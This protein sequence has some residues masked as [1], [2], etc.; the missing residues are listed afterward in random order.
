M[1]G[2]LIL[3]ALS[4]YGCFHK[5]FN[6]T[7]ERLL[8]F[9]QRTKTNNVVVR[10]NEATVQAAVKLLTQNRSAMIYR[11]ECEVC[12]MVH[13]GPKP[14]ACDS[15]GKEGSLVHQPDTHQETTIM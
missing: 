8:M 9:A 1:A 2:R 13:T 14:A 12:G 15:C 11:W 10:S 7:Q 5:S 3:D 4:F 6:S